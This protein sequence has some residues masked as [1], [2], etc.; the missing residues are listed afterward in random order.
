MPSARPRAG[1]VAGFLSRS[2]LAVGAHT[3]LEL[4]I[5]M[6]GAASTP[7]PRAFEQIALGV[8]RAKQALPVA[9]L[10]H[11]DAAATVGDKR[12]TSA[13]RAMLARRARQSE[14]VVLREARRASSA[15]PVARRYRAEKRACESA[16][17]GHFAEQSRSARPPRP[18]ATRRRSGDLRCRRQSTRRTMLASSPSTVLKP[19]RDR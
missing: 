18:A 9:D 6:P 17:F 1:A 19:C 11:V 14:R 8:G 12:A 4:G 10:G 16:R 2:Q 15:R 7:S 13:A 3:N 5:L